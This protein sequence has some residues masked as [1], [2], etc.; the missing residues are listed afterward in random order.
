MNERLVENWLINVNEK[1][2]QIPFCQMLTAEGYTVLHLSRHGSFEEGKDVIAINPIGTP[3]AFQL[4][5]AKG[6][7]S[8]TE[9]ATY[10]DQ[11]NRLVEVPIAYPGVD[12]TKPRQ[13]FFVTNGELDEE[14]RVEIERRNSDWEK[15]GHPILQVITKGALLRRLLAIQDDFW[16]SRLKDDRDLLELYLDNGYGILQKPKFAAFLSRLL[17]NSDTSRPEERKRALVSASIFSTYALT[18][19]E[20]TKNFVALIEGWTIYLASLIGYVEQYKLLK[21]HWEGTLNLVI[22]EIQKQLIDLCDEL[23]QRKSYVVGNA[24]VDPPFYQ[25]RLTLLISLM[26]VLGMWTYRSESLVTADHENWIN[27][28]IWAHVRELNY[29]GDAAAPQILAVSWYMKAKG[30]PQIYD[31]ILDNMIRLVLKTNTDTTLHGLPDPYHDLREVV[32][33]VYNI[34][35]TMKHENFFGRSYTLKWIIE[36][37]TRREWKGIIAELWSGITH[38]DFAKFRPDSTS[39]FCRWHDE[40]GNLI[41]HIPKKPQSWGELY[42]E[43]FVID[44]KYIPKIFK[45][46]PN[47][48]LLFVIV[49]PHRMTDDIVKFLDNWVGSL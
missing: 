37:M 19:F 21:K 32:S 24:I 13:V 14:V 2:F 4:K 40:N 45:K 16:P 49:F 25:G 39:D 9:W 41:I 44:E 34:S 30:A 15:R 27:E 38:V 28:F 47:L 46:Y 42:K 36:L 5:G 48:L 22:M 10:I 18:P 23:R 3:C 12:K 43:A 7:I 6:K 1:T 20:N 29:W 35:D 17:D 26:A 33:N 8:Q 11:V 31:R